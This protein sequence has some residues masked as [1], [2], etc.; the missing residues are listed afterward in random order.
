MHLDKCSLMLWFIVAVIIPER[1]MIKYKVFI[2]IT[3]ICTWAH[4]ISKR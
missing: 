4:W 1:I 3:C 2:C